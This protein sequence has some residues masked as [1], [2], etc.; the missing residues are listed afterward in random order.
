MPQFNLVVKFGF[1]VIVYS[2]EI[3]PDTGEI[4]DV[5]GQLF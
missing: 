2:P 1:D 5:L 4:I 3:S